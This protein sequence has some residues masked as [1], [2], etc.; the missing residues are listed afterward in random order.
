MLLVAATAA[1][2]QSGAVR[3][4]QSRTG[5]AT[6]A[7]A[8][9][10]TLPPSTLPSDAA[11]LYADASKYVERKFE[12]FKQSRVP[13]SRALAAETFQQQ[14]ELA[15]RHAAQLVARGNLA[16]SDNYY[17]GLLYH[18]AD[19]PKDATAPLRRF[20]TERSA[21]TSPE[22][23]QEARLALGAEAAAEGRA[24]EAESLLADY[25]AGA[26]VTPPSR[27]MPTTASQILR[28]VVSRKFIS[29]PPD[30]R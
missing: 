1:Y 5:A 9:P 25:T 12:E 16:G 24:D 15:A 23:L 8:T 13:F 20:L 17:L 29:T 7:P 6:A 27:K 21:D 2:A 3:K 30:L 11:T 18:L 26:P 14:R 10:E 4:S 19:K 28:R 22:Q